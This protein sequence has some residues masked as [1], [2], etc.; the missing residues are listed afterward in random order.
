MTTNLLRAGRLSP[1]LLVLAAL[2]CA[3]AP[4]TWE[5]TSNSLGCKEGDEVLWQ[6]NFATNEAK[7][8]FHPLRLAGSNEPLTSSKPSDHRWHYGLWFAWKYINGV[9][10]WEEDKNGRS[11]G[12]TTWDPPT[13]KAHD[14]G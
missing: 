6:F 4:V 2:S 7:P 3:A 1:A 14:D 9:N 12:T 11:E 13:I 8:Y 5:R 10:Y